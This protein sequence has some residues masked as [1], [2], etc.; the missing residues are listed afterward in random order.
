MGPP[1]LTGGLWGYLLT[2]QVLIW[3]RA[4]SGDVE[5]AEG[6]AAPTD[7]RTRAGAP[8]EP[9]PAP[10]ERA[11]ASDRCRGY[12]DVMGQWD[13]PFSCNTDTYLY[14]CGTCHYRFCCEFAHDRLDQSTCTNYDTP[15]WVN[16]GKPPI[17]VDDAVE[18]PA[19]DKTNMIVYIICGVVAVMVLVGIFTKLGLERAR[20]PQTEMNMSR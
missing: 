6:A 4:H 3:A 15:N 5:Q 16:T 17:K 11:P 7:N 2:G 9:G 12:Y 19:K 20:R 10:T 14:C 1:Y 8:G 18:G 13:P